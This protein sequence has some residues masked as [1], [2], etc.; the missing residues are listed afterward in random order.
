V[1]DADILEQLATEIRQTD[2]GAVARQ[3]NDPARVI[4]A[5]VP[6]REDL[7]LCDVADR[8]P[9]ADRAW[10]PTDA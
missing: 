9:R 3:L 7:R 8:R 5:G 2:L 6:A 1:T 10:P 4:I